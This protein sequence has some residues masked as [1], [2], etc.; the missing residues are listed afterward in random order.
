MSVEPATRPAAAASA[1]DAPR[2]GIV[3]RLSPTLSRTGERAS[4]TPS[5][6]PRATT[7]LVAAVTVNAVA[8][9]DKFVRMSEAREFLLK[10]EDFLELQPLPA[11]VPTYE[12]EDELYVSLADV[13][14]ARVSF[15]EAELAIDVRLPAASFPRQVHD[16]GSSTLA[17]DVTQ[18]HA[19]FL[20]NYRLGYSGTEGQPGGTM[21]LVTEAALAAGG[22]L[23]RNQSSQSR[24]EHDTTSLRLETQ[25]IRDDRANLRRL[26]LG[27]AVTPAVAL[28]S[29]V[30]IG[31]ITFAKAYQLAPSYVPQ[32]LLGFRG[33]ADFP[34]EVDLYVGGVLISRQRV[35]PGP[36]ELQ[37]FHYNA[38]RRDVR[39]VVR[40]IFGRETSL[41]YPFYFST[42]G[43]AAGLH[44][45]SYQAGWLR[46]GFGTPDDHYGPAA[47]SAFHRY[48]FDDHWTAGLRAEAMAARANAGPDV[49]Y[50]SDRFGSFA[51]HAGFSRD[52][53][54]A[55]SGHALSFGHSFQAGD[56]T[57]ELTYQAYSD[58]Y[59]PLRAGDAPK[60]PRR[61]FNVVLGYARPQ[62]GSFNV[63]YQ[64]LD[65]PDQPL[66]R[67]VA[68]S[69]TRPFLE[70]FSVLATVRRLLDGGG[71]ET[72]LSL[73]YRPRADTTVNLAHLRDAKGAQSESVQ[74][75]NEQPRGEGWAY[76]VAAQRDTSDA[77]SGH[78]V[79]PR[80]EYQGRRGVI[81]AEVTSLASP[82]ARVANLYSLS[83]A[84]ALVAL[85]GNVVASRP[86]VES[87]AIVKL[88]PP[89]EGVRVYANSQ[90]VGRTDARGRILLPEI[91]SYTTSFASINDKDVPI[92]HSIDRAGKS[93][94]PSYRSGTLVPFAV[95][96]I[97]SVV[98]TLAY[99]RGGA[100]MPLEYRLATVLAGD[101]PV[102]LPT[103][104]GGEFYVEGL[105]AGRLA[106]T[107]EIDG[108]PCEFT[109]DVP[110]SEESIIHLGEVFTC[111]VIH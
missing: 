28:G 101:R 57:S 111:D 106:A 90:E 29:A 92:D 25:A 30:P 14:G 27:D 107:V 65:T 3:L 7:P 59:S 110:A 12:I 31:G 103:A 18:S 73:Q 51:A 70:R 93:F 108:T 24:T 53:D 45:Y 11:G 26:T 63:G 64:N 9:G 20:L 102:E 56:F 4:G 88:D 96:R 86:I 85:D 54:T 22:W 100:R 34:S 61:D 62:W 79:T 98:G 13:P 41:D 44:D 80:L 19:S 76:S 47:F 77:G 16:L 105:P 1:I 82:G 33:V 55:R 72:F 89:L 38:G 66:T 5:R 97:R 43:L 23:L 32:P 69:W 58:G 36:F 84:G 87:F 10:S 46:E 15:D 81:A 40:D 78:S 37:N 8:R 52:R 2:A 39:V 17:V 67:A 48:G 83:W 104:R 95:A 35:A 42:E 94:S 91:A 49:F 75:S 50:R 109:L 60:L 99:S 71:Y 6:F 74:V 21:S 68:F